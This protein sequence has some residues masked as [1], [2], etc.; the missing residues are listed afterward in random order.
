MAWRV[1]DHQALVVPLE[2]LQL[3]WHNP[4]V[5]CIDRTEI[6]DR[7]S[8]IDNG[9]VAGFVHSSNVCHL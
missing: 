3:K 2:M 1:G 5:K 9:C 6:F 7:F 8:L 4:P